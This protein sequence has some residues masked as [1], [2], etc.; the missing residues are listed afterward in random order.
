MVGTRN[1]RYDWMDRLE[2]RHPTSFVIAGPGLESDTC[3]QSGD[4]GSSYLQG[5]Q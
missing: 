2:S 3:R 1:D 5:V 4:R